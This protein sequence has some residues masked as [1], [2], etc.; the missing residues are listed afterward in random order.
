MLF[1]IHAFG[2]G[3]RHNPSKTREQIYAEVPW[4]RQW[5]CLIPW[6]LAEAA[7]SVAWLRNAVAG[8]YILNPTQ[9]KV[10]VCTQ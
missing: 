8:R 3:L 9:G 5:P 4:R 10:M 1:L 7:L 2:A 6:L